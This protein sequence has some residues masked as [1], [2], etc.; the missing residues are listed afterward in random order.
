MLPSGKIVPLLLDD[1]GVVF[2]LAD[3]HR[4][5]DELTAKVDELANRLGGGT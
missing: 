3:L 4:K 5:V 1:N 2:G